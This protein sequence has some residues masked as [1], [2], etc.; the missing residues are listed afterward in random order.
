MPEKEMPRNSGI[1]TGRWSVRFSSRSQQHEPN[2]H[3]EVNLREIL[4]YGK[5]LFASF[6]DLEI[7]YDR[8]PRNKIWKVLRK[9][10]VNGQLYVPLSHSTA[11]RRFVF[12]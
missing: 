11:D 12:G 4:E 6:V 2:L 3:S 1:K 8:V 5:Y 9:Y 7:A 10:G